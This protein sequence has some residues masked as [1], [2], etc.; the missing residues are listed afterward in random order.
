MQPS[1]SNTLFMVDSLPLK[2][3]AHLSQ[4][5]EGKKGIAYETNK[6]MKKKMYKRFPTLEAPLVR[7]SESL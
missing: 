4:L 5:T 1:R 6:N 7:S 3:A 2:L